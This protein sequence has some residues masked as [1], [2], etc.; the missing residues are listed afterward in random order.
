MNLKL[1]AICSFADLLETWNTAIWV[2]IHNILLKACEP[3]IT[4]KHACI[5]KLKM[6][7]MYINTEITMLQ[8]QAD[9]K[10]FFKR[11]HIGLSIC[12]SIFRK[13]KNFDMQISL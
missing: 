4:D 5:K 2:V 12:K 9:L 10:S 6:H 3:T 7:Y 8:Q 13:L 11:C 1:S